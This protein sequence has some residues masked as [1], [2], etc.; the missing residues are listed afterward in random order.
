M[1]ASSVSSFLVA[2]VVVFVPAIWASEHAVADTSAGV[3]QSRTVRRFDNITYQIRSEPD[4]TLADLYVPIG[5]EYSIVVEPEPTPVLDSDKPAADIAPIVVKGPGRGAILVVHG[6]GWIAGDK[7]PLGAFCDDFSD[8]GFVVLNINYRHAPK[9]KFPAPLD[10]VR[11]GLLY[12]VKN[13]EALRV[14]V[15]RI[16]A[17]GYSAGGHLTALAAVLCDEPVAAQ[18]QASDWPDDDHRWSLLP[19]IAAECAGAPPSDFREIPIDNQAF[20]Y[21]LGGSR[22]DRPETYHAASP[23]AFASKGDPP[24]QLIHGE[25]DMIVPIR[26]SQLFAETLRSVEVQV[27]LKVIENHGHLFSM[28]HPVTRSTASE[29]FTRW[30]GSHHDR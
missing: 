3:V 19:R 27:D 12:L 15:D 22:R 10:D 5:E 30:L 20:T 13:A 1:A 21:F 28:L 11:M 4:G 23:A 9:S 25:T 2:F 24:I 8:R 29:F 14:D 17:F 26:S 18:R 6:G 7:W 16:G